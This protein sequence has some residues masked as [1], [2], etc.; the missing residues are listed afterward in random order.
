MEPI[1][2]TEAVNLSEKTLPN[3]TEEKRETHQHLTPSFLILPKVGSQAG[4]SIIITKVT[5]GSMC[6][7]C[8]LAKLD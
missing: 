7:Q 4:L 1:R 3:R 2:K 6:S 8:L 5:L